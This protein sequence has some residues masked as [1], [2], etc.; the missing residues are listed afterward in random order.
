MDETKILQK[1]IEHDAKLD[2]IEDRFNGI[3]TKEDIHQINNSLDKAM[4]ILQRLD[5][6]R[7]FT[8]EWIRGVEGEVERHSQEIQQ[9]KQNL[10]I[11]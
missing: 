10:H 6:E 11:K 5:Q 8:Q 4:V 1:L 7:I 2:Q 3:A 9:I